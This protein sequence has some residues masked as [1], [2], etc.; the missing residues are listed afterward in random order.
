MV[1][2]HELRQRDA[3]GDVHPDVVGRVL[4]V[5]VGSVLRCWGWF[6]CKGHQREKDHP[7]A[8]RG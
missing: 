8:L 7:S 4:P 2:L 1:L 3:L 5:Q 6:F